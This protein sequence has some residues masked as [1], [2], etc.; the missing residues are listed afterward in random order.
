MSDFKTVPSVNS[1]LVSLANHSHAIA[2]TSTDGYLSSSD[3]IKLDGLSVLS[4]VTSIIS[5]TYTLAD[6]VDFFDLTLG[7]NCSIFL[8]TLMLG[9]RITILLTQDPSFN[10]T[11]TWSGLIHWAG[12]STPALPTK[13]KKN[14]IS[15][16]S[17]STAWY[18][19]LE[20]ANYV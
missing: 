5:V 1:V 15:A 16:T 18:G 7:G 14:I 13:G 20:G 9:K 4:T 3:K 19:V 6:G 12:G 8:P 17:G 2:T 10:R 11:V